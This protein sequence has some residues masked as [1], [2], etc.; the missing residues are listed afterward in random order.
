MANGKSLQ[1][2]HSDFKSYE[3]TNSA[4]ALQNSIIIHFIIIY[5]PNLPSRQTRAVH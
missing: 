1:L 2:F 4:L 5:L 3:A